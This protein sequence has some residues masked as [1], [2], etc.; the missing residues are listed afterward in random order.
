MLRIPLAPNKQSKG[1]HARVRSFGLL[2]YVGTNA[3]CTPNK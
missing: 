1:A 2:C 3:R